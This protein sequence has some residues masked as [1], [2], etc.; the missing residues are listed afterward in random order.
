MSLLPVPPVIANL[1]WSPICEEFRAPCTKAW[2][3]L[4]CTPERIDALRA[5]GFRSV[6]LNEGGWHHFIYFNPAKAPAD[7]AERLAEIARPFAADIVDAIIQQRELDKIAAQRAQERAAEVDE[8]ART[9]EQTKEAAVAMRSA[10]ALLLEAR[11]RQW[12]LHIQPHHRFDRI[13][14]RRFDRIA[15]KLEAKFAEFFDKR[16]DVE[17][18]AWT[19]RGV[20]EALRLMTRHGVD[21]ARASNGEGWSASDTSWG[22]WAT[23]AIGTDRRELALRVGRL[24]CAGYVNTQLREWSAA[25]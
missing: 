8:W 10:D 3:V 5:L 17:P 20:I 24:L 19:D 12:L 18:V 13:D 11:D 4:W 15:E 6:T 16:S 22:H 14:I 2:L 25:A 1:R 23:R 9:H 21:G 7:H